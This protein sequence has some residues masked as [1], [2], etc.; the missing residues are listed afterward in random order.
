[1]ALIAI[2]VKCALIVFMVIP[3][4]DDLAVQN[5]GMALV[6]HGELA[7]GERDLALSDLTNIL[8]WYAWT[9]GQVMGRGCAASWFYS[10]FLKLLE[11]DRWASAVSGVVMMH[12]QPHRDSW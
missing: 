8:I 9:R 11:F 4:V 6:G 2:I 10:F 1:M 3:S 12:Q 5:C 7:L